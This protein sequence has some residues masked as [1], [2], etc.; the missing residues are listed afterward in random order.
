[1]AQLAYLPISQEFRGTGI[2]TRL[3]GD[4]ELIAQRAGDT[5]IVVTATPSENTV[6]F[7]LGRGYRPMP[8]PLP[9]LFELEP[10]EIHM[11]RAI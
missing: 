10:E 2:G 11:S 1:M 4:L 8:Q 7:Y 9:E 5:E 3:T 6:H